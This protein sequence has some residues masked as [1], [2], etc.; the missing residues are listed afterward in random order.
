VIAIIAMLLA[1]LMP[2]LSAVK[3]QAQ[4]VGCM[5][6]LSQWG[7]IFTLYTEDHDGHFFTGYYDYTDPNGVTH[8]SSDS[9][10][11]PYAMESY[12]QLPK[13]KFC[14]S[15]G[16]SSRWR[17]RDVWGNESDEIFSGSYGLNGWV[18]DTP[19]DITQTEG[20]DTANNW[21]TMDILN[22]GNIP[23]MA[24]AVWFTGRPESHDLPPEEEGQLDMERKS[25]ADD[26]SSMPGGPMPGMMSSPMG[27]PNAPEMGMPGFLPHEPE[28]AGCEWPSDPS[29]HMRRFTVNRHRERTN[30]LFMDGMI[31][32]IS[33]KELW[34]LKWHKNYDTSAPLPQ[35]PEWMKD[36]KDPN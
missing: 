25:G 21:R 31:R 20:H 6:N 8:T 24:D 12:Y 3:K 27:E 33:P 19:E 16:S 5:S 2:A 17:S 32:S 4:R 36:F 34:R 35:W 26:S 18:G 22:A 7:L 13:L 15:A 14:P 9:D 30:V 23:L 28:P 10:L 11:W 1:I 29:N